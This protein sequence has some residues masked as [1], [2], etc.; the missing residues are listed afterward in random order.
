LGQY[1]DRTDPLTPSNR[2]SFSGIQGRISRIRVSRPSV[3]WLGLQAHPPRTGL[4]YVAVRV[5]VYI[6]ALVLMVLV[7]GTRE[8][9]LL[10]APPIGVLAAA[11]T[12]YLL[13]DTPLVGRR[14]TTL[15]VGVGLLLAELTWAFGY[16]NVASLVGGAALWLG[17]YVLSGVIEHGALLNLDRRIAAEYSL[18]ASAGALVILAVARPWSA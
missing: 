4:T 9:G 7:Y 6:L 15:S 2:P 3:G 12:W 11:G 17:F 14:R 16:W 10:I 13:G 8:R 1:A 5:T 18:V